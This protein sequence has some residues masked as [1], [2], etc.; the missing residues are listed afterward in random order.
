MAEPSELEPPAPRRR[1]RRVRRILLVALA[2]F[3][4]AVAAALLV[5]LPYIGKPLIIFAGT[6]LAVSQLEAALGRPV[7]LQDVDLR[8]FRRQVTAVGL[9]VSEPGSRAA[10]AGFERLDIHLRILPLLWRRLIIR[11][12][13]LVNPRI[14]IVRTGPSTFNVSDLLPRGEGGGSSGGG[15]FDYTIERLTVAGGTL[16]FEDR[17][18]SPP[19]VVEATDLRLELRDVSTTTDAAAGTATLTFVLA[20][21]PVTLAADGIRGSP[22]QARA[23]LEV[24]DLDLARL[25]GGAREGDGLVPERGVLGT[26]LALT[27]DAPTGARLDGDLTVRDLA[28]T[29]RGQVAPFLTAPA[30]SLDARGLSYRDGR[31][32]A[33]RLELVAEPTVTDASASFEIRPLR[34]VVEDASYPAAGPAR[35]SLTAALADRGALEVRGTATLGSARGEPGGS[36]PR[37]RPDAPG[38]VHPRHRPDHAGRRPARRRPHGC[39]RR[40][41]R[42]PGRGRRPGHRPGPA[43][44]GPDGAVRDA[45]PAD[46]RHPGRPRERR[47]RGGSRAPRRLRRPH[48]GGRVRHAAPPRRADG[49][50]PDARKMRPG[51]LAGPP[52]SGSRRGIGPADR[53]RSRARSTRPPWRPTCGPRSATWT[54]LAPPGTSLPTAR[55]TL[56]GGR[57]GAR[58]RLVYGAPTLRLDGDV[59]VTDGVLH[60]PGQAEPFVLHPELRTAITGLTLGDGNL[61]IQRLAVSGTPTVVDAT[62]TPPVRAEFTRLALTAEGAAWPAGRPTRFAIDAAVRDGGTAELAGTFHPATLAADVRATLRDVA[63]ARAAPY[64]PAGGAIGHVA[65][66]AAVDATLRHDRAAGLRLAAE[67]TIEDA[68]GGGVRDRAAAAPGAPAGLPAGRPRC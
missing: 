30:V 52:G 18:V 26:R 62:V 38:A 27:Y 61:A 36:G 58:L 64:L 4:V 32:A 37:R 24:P 47:R 60:R 65:G 16:A 12:L 13:T 29:R 66:K 56:T 19:R 14:R 49:A 48:A 55:S 7:A 21:T 51:P 1:R 28:V 3:L 5:P 63:L 42:A 20:G 6:P 25:F 50:R 2:I 40:R 31:A 67:G 39:L 54:W 57:L 45:S 17:T 15:V 33:G 41:H 10:F 46:A 22:A 34:L 35:V 23:R 68:G 8:V 59:T 11:E 53:W 43:P 9:A 44:A